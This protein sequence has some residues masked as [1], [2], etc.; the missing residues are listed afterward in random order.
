MITVRVNGRPETV[1]EGK[2]LAALLQR[3]GTPVALVA[4]EVNRDVVPRARHGETRLREG[5]QVEIVQF[6]GGGA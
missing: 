5:D 2:T 1:E 4:V 6:V 3:L